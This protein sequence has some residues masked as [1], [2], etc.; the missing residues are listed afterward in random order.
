[1]FQALNASDYDGAMEHAKN[2]EKNIEDQIKLGEAMA[3][4]SANPVQKK[5][6]LEAVS[7]L[8]KFKPQLVPAVAQVIANPE[9]QQAKE[10]LSKVVKGLQEGSAHLSEA[11]IRPLNNPNITT[12]GDLP[13]SATDQE[14]T[15]INSG[16]SGLDNLDNLLMEVKVNDEPRANNALD[17]TVSDFKKQIQLARALANKCDDPKLKKALL[18]ACDTLAKLLPELIETTKLAMGDPNNPEL[19]KKLAD[20]ISRVR[21]A[22]ADVSLYTKEM[23]EWRDEVCLLIKKK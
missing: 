13:L 17:A 23:S 3:A 10:Q 21:N 7:E 2:L 9:S 22:A 4:T 19:Q 15:I 18:D 14:K 5:K 16:L 6:I 8:K 1:M 12:L 11:S 20:V